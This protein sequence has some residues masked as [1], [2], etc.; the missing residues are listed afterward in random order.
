MTKFSHLAPLSYLLP[1]S[2][3]ATLNLKLEGKGS[4]LMQFILGSLLGH[5]RL[6][7]GEGRAGTL[8]KWVMTSAIVMLILESGSYRQLYLI[9]QQ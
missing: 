7:K 8:H 1:V 9:L 3:K 5:N 2:P 4:P 6:E